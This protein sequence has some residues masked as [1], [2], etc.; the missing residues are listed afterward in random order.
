MCRKVPTSATWEVFLAADEQSSVATVHLEDTLLDVTGQRC[1][2]PSLTGRLRVT[3]RDGQE[4]E[5]PLFQAEPLVFKLSKNWAGEGRR[6]AQVTT[7]HFIV[8]VPETWQRTGHAPVEPDGCADSA[9]QAHYFH[10]DADASV[11]GDGFHEWNGS[12]V[13]TRIELVGRCIYDDSDDGPL[14][15]GD[16]PAL[17]SSSGIVWSRV[18]EEA[19]HGWGQTFQPDRQTLP[20]VLAGREGRFYLR[21]YGSEVSLLDSMAFRYVRDLIRVEVDG[22]EYALDT[23]IVPKKTGYART[24]V[25]FIG[26]DG[27]P[28]TPVLSPDTPQTVAVS[29]AIMVPPRPEADRV[30][31]KFGSGAGAVYI[32]LDLPRIWWRLEDGR[33]GSGEWRDTPLV[34]TREEFKKYAYANAAL[35]LLSKR[36]ESVRAGFDDEVNQ[37]YSRAIEADRIAI[38]LADFVDHAQ[39]DQRLNADA[40]FQV[41]WAAEIVPLIVISADPV[42]EIVSFTAKPAAILAGDEATLEWTTRDAD[43]ARAAI[44]PDAGVVESEGIHTVS[45]TETTR[46]TLTL[47]ISGAD[48]IGKTVTVTVNSPPPPVGQRVARVMSPA[49]GWRRGKG[50]STGELRDAGLK[51]CDAVD[52]SIPFDRRRRTTHRVN[53]EAIRSMLDA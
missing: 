49:G 8:I 48:D 34:M 19:E 30:S 38:P 36:K 50:F 46:Y 14:F 52:R 22:T 29:G 17:E 33:P 6:I 23:V 5:V 42:P 41:E 32:V 40:H 44:E 7:G 47:A 26:A 51:V 45:P 37:R 18:G 4:H 35:L 43:D 25:R 53:V 16:A 10:R 1:R 39:I 13:A 24:E 20:D 11:G 2:L 12:P 15:V 28:R 21:V 31:C 9:F 27:S 3:S